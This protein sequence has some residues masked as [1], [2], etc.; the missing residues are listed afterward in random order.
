[1][2]T[3]ADVKHRLRIDNNFND[4]Q[5]QALMY[6][7]ESSLKATIGY[8]QASSYTDAKFEKLFDTFVCEYVRALYFQI[9]N[10]RMLDVMQAQ[11]QALISEDV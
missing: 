11:L 5:I 4:T 3:L 10:Q 6:A 9:D 2:I 1:M 8:D 7:A